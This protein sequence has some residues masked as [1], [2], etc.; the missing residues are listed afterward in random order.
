MGRL[1]GTSSR[2]ARA[3]F[4]LPVLL[5]LVISAVI[6]IG[7]GEEVRQSRSPDVTFGDPDIGRQVI[8]DRGCGSCHR[9]PGVPAADGLVGPPLD[10][11]GRRTFIAGELPNTPEN[12]VRWVRDPQSVE[13]GTAM[14]DLG[15]SLDEARDVA[16]Y[17]A[18]LR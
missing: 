17:L 4:V 5:L 15:L 16:A 6:A 11:M 14:P 8:E 12:M 18:G 7:C 1:T 3:A 13:P 9:I 10:A 2:R